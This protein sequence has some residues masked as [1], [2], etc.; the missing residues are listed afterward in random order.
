[1]DTAG[2][3]RRKRSNAGQGGPA[4]ERGFT[5]IGLLIFVAIVGIGLAAVGTIWRTT[6]QREKE[7]ELVFIGE[8]FQRAIRSYFERSPDAGKTFPL[9][10]EDLL[11]DRRSGNVV[12]H[13]R[14]I[15][16][17]PMTGNAE[18]GLDRQPD[19]RIVGVYSLS[20]TS[21]FRTDGLPEG[22]QVKGDTH[23]DWH[24]MAN[25]GR[26]APPPATNGVPPSSPIPGAGGGVNPGTPAGGPP[27]IEAR[28]E[29]P[30]PNKCA[31]QRR[32][33][34]LKCADLQDTARQ[35]CE[36]DSARSYATCVRDA[37]RKG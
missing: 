10:L 2:G 21:V 5:Y 25:A 15:F 36:R 23:A 22:V 27:V 32:D 24:F 19:G 9:K 6:A 31:D 7:T 14:K 11:E 30:P 4:S 20:P 26:Q 13:L 33:D 35:K 18:W 28:P 1:M 29:E 37:A 3:W 16:V 17:D 8:Q 34:M 12:R